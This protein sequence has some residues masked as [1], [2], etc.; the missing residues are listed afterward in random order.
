M[1]IEKAGRVVTNGEV[2]TTEEEIFY[3]IVEFYYWLYSE[4]VTRRHSP[5][6]MEFPL[7]QKRI[8]IGW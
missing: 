1:P 2:K 6:G 8:Y 5:N 7:C 4:L 3:G